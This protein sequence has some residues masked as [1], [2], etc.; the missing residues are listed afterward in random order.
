M[1][2]TIFAMRMWVLAVVPVAACAPDASLH[3]TVQHDP[4]Y[5]ALVDRTEVSIYVLPDS[6]CEAI[7]F[8]DIT[9]DQLLGARV[10][11]AAEGQPLEGIP[12]VDQKLI[13]ARGYSTEGFLVTAGCVAYGEVSGDQ[14]V[15]VATV[16]TATV[17]VNQTN[18]S[19]VG[20]VVTTTDA[21]NDSLDGRQVLWRLYGPAGTSAP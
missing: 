8:G 19:S 18:D 11:F 16:P 5:A 4:Q 21:H 7:E 17:S 10:A 13:V 15:I 9:E 2:D 3:V 6:T 20:Y 14:T 12:R 1:S